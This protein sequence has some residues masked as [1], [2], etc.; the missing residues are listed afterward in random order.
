M[1][2]VHE[3]I[4]CRAAVPVVLFL[5]VQLTIWSTAGF[6]DSNTIGAPGL[7]DPLFPGAGNGGIDVQNYILDISWDDKT[8]VIEAT[9]LLTI[10]ATQE[11]T[12]FNLDFHELA[13]VSL[14]VNDQ[15]A[16]FSRADNELTIV[17]PQLVHNGETFKVSVTYTGKPEPIPGSVTSG[18]NTT[19]SGVHTL[20][21]PIAAKNWFPNNNHPSDKAT[22]TFHIT[23]P[24]P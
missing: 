4:P 7:G 18:W 23:V 14:T 24:K 1:R 6:C 11:L 2:Y 16:Q 5:L 13:I 19:P 17:L 9:A 3:K 8:G 15:P 20:S 12:A 22:Y 10:K 21:E